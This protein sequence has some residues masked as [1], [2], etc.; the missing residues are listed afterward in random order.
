M[1]KIIIIFIVLIS[2]ILYKILIKENFSSYV[3]KLNENDEELKTFCSELNKLN[4]V[5][6]NT[7]LLKKYNNRLKQI[8][9]KEIKS[10]KKEIDEM[11]VNRLNKEIDNHNRYK[12]SNYN[13]VSKQIDLVNMAKKNILMD[14]NININVN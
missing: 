3:D 8:K 7:L 2:I 12:L 5:D 6:N 14:K 13:K 4:R 11:Y 9:D 1:N 10:L